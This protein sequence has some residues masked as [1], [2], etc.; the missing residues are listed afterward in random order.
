MTALDKDMSTLLHCASASDMGSVDLAQFLI[1]HGADSP[2]QEWLNSASCSIGV[3]KWKYGPCT[4][5]HSE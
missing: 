3:G 5:P 2:R 4:F 1:E